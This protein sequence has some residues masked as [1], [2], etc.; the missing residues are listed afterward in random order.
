MDAILWT[1]DRKDDWDPPAAS[2][3]ATMAGASL[4]P[5]SMIS[6]AQAVVLDVAWIRTTLKKIAVTRKSLLLTS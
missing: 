3:S 6:A 4:M 5:P 1:S 2:A